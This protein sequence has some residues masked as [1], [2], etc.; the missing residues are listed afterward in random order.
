MPDQTPA[1]VLD[2]ITKIYRLYR[3][4]SEQ[5]MDIFGLS[6]LRFWRK[7]RYHYRAALENISLTVGRGERIAIIGRNGAGKTT[8]LKLITGNFAPTHGTVTVNGSVQALMNI[9]LGFHPEFTG[10]ENIR[11]SLVYNGLSTSE[12]G[13]AIEDIVDFVELGEYLHQPIK[14]Y[15]LGMQARLYFA[16]ATAIRPD[17]LIVDE[18]LGA[19]DA[20]FSAK[21][22]DRMMNLTAGGATLILVSHAMSQVLQ[23]C[24]E[25]IWI[26]NGRIILRDK[27]L[28]V[29]NAYEKFISE[30]ER[31]SK[32]SPARVPLLTEKN[33]V[34][35]KIL[36]QL[37]DEVRVAKAQ[38][39][40]EHH[41][42]G[43]VSK[44]EGASGP[45]VLDF[46]ILDGNGEVTA[47]F[48]TGDRVTFVV[49]LGASEVEVY[50]CTVCILTYSLDGKWLTR[51]LSPEY[52]L[53]FTSQ[54]RHR[55]TLRYDCLMLGNGAYLIS[56]A[57]YKLLDLTDL[58][59]AEFYEILA[60][61]YRIQV[62]DSDPADAT[63]FHHPAVWNCHTVTAGRED[64]IAAI[65]ADAES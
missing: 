59:T 15:S 3:S 32:A 36:N 8:L 22:A 20:Y 29:V 7:P 47:N 19:G 18:V 35:D 28:T 40:P 16:T 33:W 14:T 39:M 56:V 55:V 41:F 21:S 31:R 12:L 5:A 54:A 2:G 30:L 64:R 4:P 9:G 61:S 44:W 1:V 26:E 57:T 34:T 63:M 38:A 37:V 60:R 25:A 24:N 42:E 13:A 11:S 65:V 46:E 49:N 52:H 43:G 50:P 53:D 48:K 10:Y 62:R 45:R 58:S 17:I 27:T 51:H 6:W 23:F